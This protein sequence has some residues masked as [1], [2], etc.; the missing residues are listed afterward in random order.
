MAN[1]NTIVGLYNLK[2]ITNVDLDDSCCTIT[3]S[4]LLPNPIMSWDVTILANCLTE[5]ITP[6]GTP[7]TDQ[8][9]TYKTA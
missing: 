7:I 9:Y 6:S 2:A 8:V 1:T 5:S 4:A 3:N